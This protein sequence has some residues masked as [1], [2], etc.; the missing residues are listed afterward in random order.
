MQSISSILNTRGTV[1]EDLVYA[2]MLITFYKTGLSLQDLDTKPN[3]HVEMKDVL[4]LEYKIAISEPKIN[5]KVL[6]TS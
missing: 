2:P 3:Y 5:S 4:F 1:K 6:R